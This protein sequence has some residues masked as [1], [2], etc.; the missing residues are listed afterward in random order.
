[1]ACRSCRRTILRDLSSRQGLV[2]SS[3]TEVQSAAVARQLSRQIVA[4]TPHQQRR[5]FK[6]TAQCQKSWVPEPLRKLGGMII[7]ST[8]EPYQ[9]HKA[10]EIIYKTAA[11]EAAYSISET[12]KRNG[13]VKK[14]EEGEE[15]GTGNTTWHTDFDLSP[16]F[17]TWSQVTMLHLYLVYARLRNLPVD[18][19]RSWQKQLTDHFFFDAE[20]R[21]DTMHGIS[22]RGLRHRYLKDLFIQWRGVI[23]AYDEGVA[24][25]DAVLAAAVWRNIYKAREDVDV[26]KLAAITSWM[27]ACLK[28]LDATPDHAMFFST[29][30]TFK[31]LANSEFK[32]VD[33][34]ARELEGVL[35]AAQ[36][37][38]TAREAAPKVVIKEAA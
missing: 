15:I 21:M 5:G 20:E 14:T 22:S 33:I 30:S 3:S 9:V 36:P 28:S 6:S 25:G 11:A 35:S 31:V 26:R 10:T 23:A 24:K 37:R 12:D 2:A 8:S 17:S 1:M 27:R 13:T 32:M 38:P 16:T 7:R 29:A 19:A 34:P 4:A 18:S